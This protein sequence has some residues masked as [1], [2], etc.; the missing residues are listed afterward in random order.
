VKIVDKPWFF[1]LLALA[2]LAFPLRIGELW[3]T[4]GVDSLTHAKAA[5]GMKRA[6]SRVASRKSEERPNE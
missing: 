2:S 6:T 4:P 3:F 1:G 5:G